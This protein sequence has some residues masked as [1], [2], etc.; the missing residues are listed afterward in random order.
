M[1]NLFNDNW[2]FCEIAIDEASMFKDGSPVIFEPGD[3]FDQANSESLEYKPVS[4]PH[5]WQIFHVKEL[6]KNSAGCYKK[7]FVLDDIQDSHFSVRFEGVYM[8]SEV[9]VNGKSAGQWK[10][11][12]GTFEFDISDLVQKG[13]NLIQ[14]IAVYQ[15]CNTRWYSGAGIFRDVSFTKTGKTFLAPD[16]TYFRARLAGGSKWDCKFSAE[17]CGKI[18][19]HKVRHIIKDKNGRVFWKTEG[20]VPLEISSDENE[21]LNKV[22]IGIKNQKICRAEECFSVES[23]ELW[24]IENPHLYKVTTELIDSTGTVIDSI[25]Q[26]FGFKTAEFHK[27]NGFFLN[28]RHVKIYGA[29]HHH[30]QG[31]LG[32][33]FDKNAFRRQLNKLKEMGVNSV[34]CSH[35]PPPKGWMDLCDEMGILVDDEAFDMWEKPKTPFDYGNHFNDWCERDTASWVRKDRNH[36]CLIMWSIGNEIYDTHMGNGLEITKKL[37]SFVN[38]HDPDKNALVT[39]ASNYMMTDGAQ[40]CAKEIETVGYNYL[41]RLYDEHHEKYK[42]LPDWKIYGSETGSTIQS[43]GIYHFPETLKLV[44]FSDMQCS[45]LGNCTTTWGAANTQTVIATDRDCSFSAGQYIWTGWDYIGEPTPYH[46][47][48]SFFGQIDTAG[49]PKDTFYLFKSEWAYKNTEPFVHLLPYW[50]WNEG[51]IIDVKAYT[52]AESVELFFNGK[53]LGK[54]DI[55]HKSGKAPFGQWQLDYH[56]GEITAVGYDENGK[57]ICRETKRSFEDPAKIRLIPET[58][59]TGNL[60]FVQVMTEDKN[61]TLVENARNYITVR[62]D[63]DGELVGLDNGDSTDYDEYFTDN[64]K[65]HSRKLFQNRLIA[66]IRGKTK[67]SSFTVSAA[68]KGLPVS[69]IK[70]DGSGWSENSE[71]VML[72][73]EKDFVPVRKIEIICD[74]T[75]DLTK[76]NKEISVTAKVLPENASIKTIQWNPVLKECVSSDYIEVCNLQGIGSGVEKATIKAVCD[77]ECILRLGAKNGQQHDE[78]LSD[79]NFTVNGVGNPKLNPYKL[80]EACRLSSWDPSKEKP[81][82]S[83]ESG[84]SNRGFGP[85]WISFD[86][87]DFGT[88]GA[89]TIHLPIFSFDT[90][91][92]VEVWDGIPESSENGNN[93]NAGKC[94]LKAT[95]KHSSIYNTFSEN[96]FTLSRRLFGVHTIS[97]AF[98]T[99]LVFHGFYFDQ[100]AKALSK[101]SALDA[102]DIVGDS[103]T[104]TEDAVTGIGNNVNLDFAN[105][106]FGNKGAVKLTICG[107]SN[108]EN[109]TIN[110]KLFGENGS[111][112]THVI[113]FTHTDDYEEKTFELTEI[114]GLQKV[115]FVFLP[116]CNFDFRWFKFSC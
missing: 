52:N 62:I 92:P 113:E 53:S 23:P 110:L 68:S 80:I 71:E 103:F 22:A 104:K 79:L 115:S 27:E 106:D 93:E 16:G 57:E 48:N 59:D 58:E 28:G 112:K 35:N 105:M 98:K 95:Y 12:Y 45:S 14:V 64:K 26:N 5:D 24:D 78:I 94:L 82:V 83:L 20:S 67:E 31:A 19:G 44:T 33:A 2:Q 63:G 56:K 85:T 100:T 84:I 114:T 60:F 10:Y 7:T 86:K 108:T 101:L 15:N 50:D 38:Y 74:G 99:E 111:V 6:Y 96:V 97:I 42:D 9:W 11:G 91:L 43:R 61:K 87:V 88:E 76:E 77:G 4:V 75:T 13:E 46:S 30:D 49:F 17:V 40:E 89:D 116:G 109:N 54:Q 1:T 25:E 70:Y 3:F 51:Q 81:V 90:E 29:C 39:I 41:E 18:D 65:L 102:D 73:P 107:K 69:S 72:T 66:I 47:K 21:Y 37:K 32:A 8:N 34:R 36:P 55:N